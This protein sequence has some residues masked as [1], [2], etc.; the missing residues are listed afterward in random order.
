MR[1]ICFGDSWTAGHGVEEDSKYKEDPFP[2]DGGEFIQKL[3]I[4]NGWP[5]WVANKFDCPFVVYAKCGESNLAIAKNTKILVESGLLKSDDV[6]IIMFSYPYR[7]IDGPIVNYTKI[8]ELLKPYK[9]FYFNSFYSTFSYEKDFDY[10][11]LPYYFI[12]P[13]STTSDILKEYELKN[14]ISVW[15][16]NSRNVWSDGY[17]YCVGDY[18]PNLLGYKII[19]EFIYDKIKNLV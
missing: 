1:L 9:H 12:D 16:Y 15:E 17:N 10:D 19:A 4:H 7:D 8:E 14:D 11:S 3:R 18:H 6:I 2:E 5:R 13:K